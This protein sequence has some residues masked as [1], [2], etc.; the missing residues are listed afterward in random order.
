MKLSASVVAIALLVIAGAAP[1][2]AVPE[3][4]AALAQWEDF[5]RTAWSTRVVC[6][7]NLRDGSIVDLEE[8]Y[9]D[10]G[11]SRIRNWEVTR[12]WRRGVSKLAYVKSVR[13][14]DELGLLLVVD[15][16]IDNGEILRCEAACRQFGIRFKTVNQWGAF[17]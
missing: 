15:Q 16:P 10:A 11:K 4:G 6:R 13:P 12:D 14:C 1:S 17:R 3:V 8:T 5:A 2:P 7:V 9:C